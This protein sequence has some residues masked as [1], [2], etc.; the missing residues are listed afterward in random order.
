MTTSTPTLSSHLIEGLTRFNGAFD[1]R[2]Y[3]ESREAAEAQFAFRY[4]AI[5]CRIRGE[6]EFPATETPEIAAKPSCALP[7][8]P[9]RRSAPKPQAKTDLPI[10]K[11]RKRG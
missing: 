1:V 4:K 8:P 11:V 7:R 10:V 2:L 6:N 3:A 5:G 9:A